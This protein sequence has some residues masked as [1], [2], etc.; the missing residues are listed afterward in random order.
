VINAKSHGCYFG[1]ICSFLGRQLKNKTVYLKGAF[2]MDK[3]S[4]EEKI[5]WVEKIIHNKESSLFE[6]RHR[7]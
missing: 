1:M 5:Q 2:S 4:S 6:N 7:V 3:I